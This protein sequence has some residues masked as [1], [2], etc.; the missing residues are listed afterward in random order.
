MRKAMKIKREEIQALRATIRADTA[1]LK[2]MSSKRAIEK[3]RRAEGAVCKMIFCN[4]GCK[5]L[6]GF[7]PGFR[8]YRADF[9]NSR[10]HRGAESVCI[11]KSFDAKMKRRRTACAALAKMNRQ[12]AVKLKGLINI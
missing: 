4:P 1:L 2:K 12:E 8:D 7:P 11:H 9:A 5:S 6:P 10:R 3:Y